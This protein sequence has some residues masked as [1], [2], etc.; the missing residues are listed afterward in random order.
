MFN[1]HAATAALLLLA[2]LALAAQPV[3]PARMAERYRRA[4]AIQA[5][6]KDGWLMNG[7]VVP[8]WIPGTEQLW[9]ARQTPAGRRYV[10]VDASTGARSDLFDHDKLAAA[11]AKAAAKPASAENLKL[12]AVY[13]DHDRNL[14]FTFQGKP[15][16][17]SAQGELFRIRS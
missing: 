16:R 10:V 7:S 15:W 13:V 9:Y 17:Y 8:H 14:R 1:R 2:P 11:L 12:A 4:A 6:R 5:Q 3:P